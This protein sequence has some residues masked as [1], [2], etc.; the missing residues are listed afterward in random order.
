MVARHDLIHSSS[1]HQDS[2]VELNYLS[3]LPLEVELILHILL[4]WSFA[5]LRS[6]QIFKSVQPFCLGS[7]H[8]TLSI[9]SG[10]FV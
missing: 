6:S 10:G 2:L 1:V 3:F 5:F 7:F 4:K 8:S 9:L